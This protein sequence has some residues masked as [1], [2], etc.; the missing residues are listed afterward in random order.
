MLLETS[1][2]M[3]LNKPEVMIY[4]TKS[5]KLY[6]KEAQDIIDALLHIAIKN[7]PSKI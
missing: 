3:G 4:T 7:N 2:N 5:Y 1:P 6:N